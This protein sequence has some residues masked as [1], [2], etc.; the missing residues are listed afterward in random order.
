MTD[1][2]PRDTVFFI[3]PLEDSG[4]YRGD[5]RKETNEEL[6]EQTKALQASE[7][8]LQQQQEE[9]RQ[10]NE[11]LEQQTRELAEQQ[12]EVKEKNRA[13]DLLLA[14]YAPH[15]QAGADY[16]PPMADEVKRGL[17]KQ[18]LFLSILIL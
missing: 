13:L 12:D 1:S 2:S 10:T 9:L 18:G 3:R 16:R 7:S 6:G 17:G 11:E 4:P 8:Q 5:Y 15:L 14:K